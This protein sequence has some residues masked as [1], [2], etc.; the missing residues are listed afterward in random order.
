MIKKERPP[1][2]PKFMLFSAHQETLAPLLLIFDNQIHY[3]AMP[4]G[5]AIFFEFFT[6]NEKHGKH[7]LYVRMFFKPSAQEPQQPI[8]IEKL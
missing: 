4:A 2:F 1:P 8:E 5:S 7:E 3:S 6:D